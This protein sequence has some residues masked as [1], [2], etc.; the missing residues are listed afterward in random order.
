MHV[1][2]IHDQE[3]PTQHNFGITQGVFWAIVLTKKCVDFLKHTAKVRVL[4]MTA[5]ADSLHSDPIFFLP[6]FC[7]PQKARIGAG[8]AR[9]TSMWLKCLE[10]V[11]FRV[12]GLPWV[13][14]RPTDMRMAMST[15][16][17][18]H[19]GVQAESSFLLSSSS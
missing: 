2:N 6:K 19:L 7:C 17:G 1:S 15:A 12:T 5:S 11:R 14:L 3:N 13:A 4:E 9:D 16:A 8:G 10:S 18:G